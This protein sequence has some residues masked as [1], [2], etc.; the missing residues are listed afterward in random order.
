MHK[1]V[2]NVLG[3]VIALPLALLVVGVL[4]PTLALAGIR[5]CGYTKA[6]QILLEEIRDAL[7]VAR[8]RIY[9]SKRD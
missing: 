2:S 1:I 6:Y 9:A 8:V 4:C 5:R 3:Y 7:S